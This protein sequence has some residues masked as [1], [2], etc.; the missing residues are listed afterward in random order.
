MDRERLRVGRIG[1][2][3]V[4]PI[5]YPLERGI[6]DHNFSFVYGSP[7]ELNEMMAKGALDIS[8]ISSI[9]YARR[10]D[11]Y[12][13]LPDLSISSKGSVK[14]VLL[15]SMVPM[16]D[17]DGRVIHFTPQSHSS[18]ALVKILMKQGFNL[19]CSYVVSARPLWQSKLRKKPVA[20]LAIGDEALYWA[21]QESFPYMW[22]LGE[23]WYQWTGLPFVFALWVCSKEFARKSPEILTKSSLNLLEAKKWGLKNLKN[24]ISQ[25]SKTTF[26]TQ[27]ELKNYFEHLHYDLGSDAIEGLK[28][29]FNWLYIE[30]EIPKKPSIDILELEKFEVKTLK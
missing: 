19:N 8:V 4:L 13:I 1:Y 12:L 2:L 11:R 17:L 14:S 22:D 18:V 3:N 5:Y 16:D 29:Y 6:V 23:L 27:E 9:E 15:F 28:S 24:I 25:A 7:S 21:K 26:L 20:Y 30:G 10:Y